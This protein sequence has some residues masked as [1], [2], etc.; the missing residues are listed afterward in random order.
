VGHLRKRRRCRQIS[1]KGAVGSGASCDS[2]TAVALW[3]S[4]MDEMQRG[5][6]GGVAWLFDGGEKGA[7]R[8][9]WLD[10]GRHFLK[11]AAG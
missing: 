2:S 10:G 6:T 11:E 7:G 3:R 1:P 8:K 5:S 4:M 9:T